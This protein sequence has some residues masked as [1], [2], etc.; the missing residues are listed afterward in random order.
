M[1]GLSDI[2]EKGKN[3]NVDGYFYWKELLEKFKGN[4]INEI[5][6]KKE[7]AFWRVIKSR[8]LYWYILYKS[9]MM[10]IKFV[11]VYYFYKEATSDK[12]KDQPPN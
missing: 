4:Q 12:K 6:T 7:G 8:Y 3:T 2:L 5:K 11:I 9:T 1:K 10:L